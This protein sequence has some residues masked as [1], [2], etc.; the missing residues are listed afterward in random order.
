MSDRQKRMSWQKKITNYAK[1]ANSG[2]IAEVFKTTAT[3]RLFLL[4]QMENQ[5]D[6][7]TTM[8]LTNTQ[9]NRR[10]DNV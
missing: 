8:L 2:T 6:L 1:S 9:T 5:N 4:V 10:A 3:D 7:W